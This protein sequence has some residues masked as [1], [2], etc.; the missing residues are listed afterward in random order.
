MQ[1]RKSFE[2][3][4]EIF[5]P[6]T[7]TSSYVERIGPPEELP[8]VIGLIAMA[9]SNLEATLSDTIIEMLQIDKKRGLIVTA[10]L[11]FKA[12][13]N[14]FS[15]LY[16]ELKSDYFFNTYPGFEEEYFKE[17]LKALNRCEENRNQTLHSAF[18]Q[19]YQ[20]QK[21]IIRKKITAKQKQ[22]LTIT[23]EKTSIVAL[24]NIYDSILC[25]DEEL[26]TFGIDIMKKK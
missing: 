3:H 18:I 9:F 6:V 14:L 17:L 20:T 23:A 4:L 7:D 10:E 22:G 1:D 16:H 26:K 24:F 2:E 13:L 11:S 12:K 25:V 8:A 5:A 15:S 19:N 21:A